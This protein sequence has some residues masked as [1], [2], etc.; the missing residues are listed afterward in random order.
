MYPVY[1]SILSLLGSSA[2]SSQFTIVNGAPKPYSQV[3]EDD[4][5]LMTPEENT[6]FFNILPK[7]PLVIKLEALPSI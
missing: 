5:E 4:H 3:T 2:E 7:G 6:A 1:L